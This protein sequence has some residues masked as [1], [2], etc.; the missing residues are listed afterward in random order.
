VRRR[1]ALALLGLAACQDE[2][3]PVFLDAGVCEAAVLRGPATPDCPAA[4]SYG[5]KLGDAGLPT[6]T[7]RRDDVVLARAQICDAREAI[8]LQLYFG[9]GSLPGAPG[10]GTFQLDAADGSLATCAICARFLTDLD[11]GGNPTYMYMATSGTLVLRSLGGEGGA[12]FEALLRDLRMRRVL[13]DPE[14]FET[15]PADGCETVIGSPGIGD[16]LLQGSVSPAKTAG[17]VDSFEVS[18]VVV[19]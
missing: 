12:G 10:A 16:V 19:P 8:D 4:D 3:S 6:S 7:F 18:R 13:I 5:M 2:L 9:A 15:T 11:A 17:R 14:D 1:L